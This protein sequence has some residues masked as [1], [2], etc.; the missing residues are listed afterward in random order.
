MPFFRNVRSSSRNARSF[1]R[2][3]AAPPQQALPKGI[4]AAKWG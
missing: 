2:R 1:R 4:L 3:I